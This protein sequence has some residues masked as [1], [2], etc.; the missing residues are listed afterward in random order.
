[1]LSEAQQF[2]ANT[3][4]KH[5]MLNAPPGTGKTE[6]IGRRI[7]KC[8]IEDGCPPDRILCLTHTN[9]AKRNTVDRLRQSLPVNIVSKIYIGTIHSF[10]WDLLHQIPPYSAGGWS[11][12][13]RLDRDLC[14]LS[15]TK[16]SKLFE[17][18]DRDPGDDVVTTFLKKC[19]TFE[20]QLRQDRN[21]YFKN[22]PEKPK[23]T[24]LEKLAK[25]DELREWAKTYPEYRQEM[26]DRRLFTYDH[27][28]AEAHGR[29]Q[30]DETLSRYVSNCFQH[31]IVDEFQ[32]VGEGQLLLLKALSTL[33]TRVMVAGDQN[34]SIYSFNGT[35]QD[36][37]NRIQ[38][39]FAE[40]FTEVSL[41]HNYRS[42]PSIT[43]IATFVATQEE[44][45][46]E[47]LEKPFLREYQ[48]E[49]AEV[50]GVARLIKKEIQDHGTLPDNIAILAP[51]HKTLDKMAVVLTSLGIPF[52][53]CRRQDVTL[54][55]ITQHILL[56]LKLV[57]LESEGV[58]TLNG[59]SD[60]ILF[61]LLCASSSLFPSAPKG[62]YG[63]IRSV[64]KTCRKESISP[65]EWASQNPSEPL[66]QSIR[67]IVSCVVRCCN[68]PPHRCLQILYSTFL[69]REYASVF[70]TL[71]DFT[72]QEYEKFDSQELVPIVERLETIIRSRDYSI[73]ECSRNSSAGTNKPRVRLY[74][75]HS[76]KSL[77][78]EHVYMLDCGEKSWKVKQ[79]FV[80]QIVH[81][82]GELEREKRRLFHVAV[83]RA[84][85]KL[86]FSYN[87][88]P[89]QYVEELL[90]ADL[91]TE[92]EQKEDVI[93]NDVLEIFAEE[94]EDSSVC[95]VSVIPKLS[96]T[97]LGDVEDCPFRAII[98]KVDGI[99]LSHNREDNHSALATGI[100]I[101]SFLE[102]IHKYKIEHGVFPSLL[103]PSSL[104]IPSE[105][106]DELTRYVEGRLPIWEKE[107]STAEAMFVEHTMKAVMDEGIELTGTM[108]RLMKVAPKEYVI[109]DYKTGKSNT[110]KFKTQA[111]F[112]VLLCHL[113]GFTDTK[114]V[115]FD[116]TS[117]AQP[118]NPMV[119]TLSDLDDMRARIRKCLQD[120][121]AKRP[122]KC[123]KSY[124]S[125]C[126]WSLSV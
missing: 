32:D 78:F 71:I 72:R 14:C 24:L 41:T 74:T 59:D 107:Y 38:T 46:I 28:I 124:C 51:F 89:C 126:S 83:S 73:E 33:E 31:I 61:K 101:H 117:E 22:N 70:T 49:E 121:T 112:Y 17:V 77:G 98:E 93:E 53:R 90:E 116:V 80:E 103:D 118:E 102:K 111:T 40:D 5:V 25:L 114:S 64:W 26:K 62:E 42:T 27:L 37:Y 50:I 88:L 119:I 60:S 1:M 12:A 104:N 87:E 29:L 8:I 66:A 21:H 105:R 69:P 13:H 95:G 125:W 45:T 9:E 16:A 76:S 35:V 47:N 44:V 122:R 20:Q 39:E 113:C 19:D 15:N 10:A 6:T 109:Y 18:M 36:P 106:I 75:C 123:G 99:C 2:V 54:L 100:A 82:A 30:K 92:D 58:T 94:D 68:K 110:S 48:S 86:N 115:V 85:A 91:V 11:L 57:V 67:D 52:Q 23:K 97:F 120:I 56:F 84:K 34:Q 4:D 79:N 96:A 7:L 43:A 65:Q 63:K 108:D 81:Q 3:T 55:P